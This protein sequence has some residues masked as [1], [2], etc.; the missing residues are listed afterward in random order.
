[1]V[2]LPNERLAVMTRKGN[3]QIWD[4]NSSSCV[5]TLKPTLAVKYSWLPT[6][7][8]WES[9]AVAIGSR[10]QIEIWDLD[11]G[12]CTQRLALPGCIVANLAFSDDGRFICS[13]SSCWPHDSREHR[14]GQIH[15]LVSKQCVNKFPVLDYDH[16][17][18]LATKGQW[19]AT[20]TVDLIMLSKWSVNGDLQ[21]TNLENSN[22][23]GDMVFSMDGMLLALAA[24][25]STSELECVIK[26]WCTETK[27][28]VYKIQP[29]GID[30]H[31][32]RLAL[33]EHSLAFSVDGEESVVIDLKT[34]N[35]S[36][37]LDNRNDYLIA[38][39]NDSRLLTTCSNSYPEKG[40][41]TWD[42][43]S[44]SEPKSAD[45]HSHIV[46]VLRLVSDEKTILSLSFEEIK[47][48]D[49]S[50]S[51]C[52]GTLRLNPQNRL[53]ALAVA[54]NSPIFA[55]KEESDIK[56][57]CFIPF[58]SVRTF[59]IEG[60]SYADSELAISAN[61]ERITL[62]SEYDLTANNSTGQSF[63]AIEVRDVRSTQLVRKFRAHDI[64]PSSIDFSPEGTT[65]AFIT[66]SAIKAFDMLG[67]EL[68]SVPLDDG[69]ELS[70]FPLSFKD[71]SIVISSEEGY[72]QT[73]DAKTG[74]RGN[75]WTFGRHGQGYLYD[76]SF[77]RP[78]LFCDGASTAHL[79]V[80]HPWKTYHI[81]PDGL[82]LMKDG[83]RFLWLPPDY[84]PSTA[85]VSGETIVIGTESGRVL[86]LCLSGWN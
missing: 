33:T 43:A 30:T 6:F 24:G 35:V 58:I 2:F 80:K 73:Y 63:R 82:W 52:K 41:R 65:I 66:C 51:E 14:I 50:S 40:I 68:F 7:S 64:Y 19:I 10:D 36:H 59:E 70:L 18:S 60:S 53:H 85:C 61:G 62:V 84:R 17:S 4:P 46:L 48:W 31:I 72:V 9:N 55:M 39:S 26:V 8:P 5:L 78:E 16:K 1:M 15:D 32:Q 76:H 27:E 21:W 34:G 37:K 23:D 81:R 29:P 20:R 13:T 79:Q 71:R 38:M 49:V 69:I 54:Q 75:H 3:I 83:E 28:Q 67:N 77:I 45:L 44:I 56:I 11:S 22:G 25:T 74:E 12:R 86:F 42:L 57:C 47:I